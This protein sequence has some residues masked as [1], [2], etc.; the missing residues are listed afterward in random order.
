MRGRCPSRRGHAPRSIRP[1]PRRASSSDGT[2]TRPQLQKAAQQVLPPQLAATFTAYDL[3][4]RCATELAA[5]GDLT[6]AASL[7]SRKQATTLNRYGR[8]EQSAAARVLAARSSAFGAV[9]WGNRQTAARGDER[10][11]ILEQC[12]VR[13]LDPASPAP[14]SGSKGTTGP[15]TNPDDWRVRQNNER[16]AE[17][18]VAQGRTVRRRGLEPPR[19]LPR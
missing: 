11:M 8:R 6:G 14:F 7:M 18:S 17:N 1:V 4:H 2:T 16:P 15:G 10:S 3:R 19:E 13:G 9:A 12:E 5:T